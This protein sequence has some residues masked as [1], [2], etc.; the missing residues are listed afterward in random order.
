MNGTPR[1]PRKNSFEK[2]GM[3]TTKVYRV[4]T[5]MKR[6]CYDETRQFYYRYGGRGITVC[7]EWIESFKAFYSDMGDIPFE[8]AQIDRIDND[9]GYSKE[10][11]RW[12]S[13]T[14]NRRNNSTTVLTKEIARKI[15]DEY[16][17]KYGNR[18]ALARKYG[19]TSGMIGHILKGRA[20]KDA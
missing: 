5:E 15:R 1:K 14:Q 2:H 9:K 11:C 6:R 20:W 18:I 16:V 7:D 10:N 8:H 12:A 3:G 4:W 17:P 13:P 19:V